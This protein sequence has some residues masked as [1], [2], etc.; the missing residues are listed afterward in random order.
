[1]ASHRPLTF[2]V[3]VA[4]LVSL[5]PMG[6]PGP[7]GATDGMDPMAAGKTSVSTA[8]ID[9]KD[10]AK[11]PHYFG[12]YSNW[13]NSPF[14]LPDVSVDIVGA[15]TGAT[16]VATVG[17]NG[18]VTGIAL[19]SPGSGYT[20]ATVIIAGA[21]ISATAIA[22]VTSRWTRRAPATLARW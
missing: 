7:A 15:G 4:L 11:V 19:T 2:L 13:A 12:P 6:K 3:L 14:T 22:T 16:A 21:G 20:S 5:V 9:P 8:P 10:E 17:A 18:A 1:M